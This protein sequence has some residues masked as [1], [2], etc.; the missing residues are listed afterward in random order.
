MTLS[1]AETY[2]LER[3]DWPAVRS[4]IAGQC[5][6]APG[7]KLMGELVP[8]LSREEALG[9]YQLVAQA[10]EVDRM[11]AWPGLTDVTDPGPVLSRA[12]R[13][14]VLEGPELRDLANLVVTSRSYYRVLTHYAEGRPALRSW[15]HALSP[16]DSFH[17]MLELSVDADGEL[18]ATA[19]AEL[20][21]LRDEVE[22]R[23]AGI[24][25]RLEEILKSEKF[26]PF[27]QDDFFT[28][29][30][31]RFVVPLKAGAQAQIK[32]IVHDTSNT[33][34]TVFIEPDEVIEANN[35][36]KTAAADLAREELRIRRELSTLAASHATEILSNAG[37]LI[38]AD[39]VIARV[40]FG[41]L[42]GGVVPQIT[43]E[44]DWSFC[45]EGLT[46]PLLKQQGVECVPNDLE[47]PARC[48]SL[49]LSGPNTGG[50]TVLLKSLGLA[51]L[52]VKAGVP[53][54]AA[55]GSRLPFVPA[56]YADIG[57]SQSLAGAVSTFSGHLFQIHRILEEAKA[58]SVA[59]LDELMSGTDPAEGA[60]LGRAVLEAL[61]ARRVL[62]VVSTHY[63][64]LKHLPSEGG[65]RIVAG[66]EFD[67]VTLRPTY[68]LR[69]GTP[70]HSRAIEVAGRLGFPPAIVE[71]ARALLPEAGREV[72][73]LVEE[74]ERRNQT[75]ELERNS[76]I[77]ER[78]D[79][80][81][82][83]RELRA[84]I[85]KLK[86]QEG[87]RLTS[88]AARLRD[89]VSE[90]RS[91]VKLL[92]KQAEERAAPPV[93]EVVKR[94]ESAIQRAETVSGKAREIELS[95]DPD[96]PL[97]REAAVPGAAVRLR[98]TETVGKI[99]SVPDSK[100]RLWVEFLG[101][102]TQTTL[103]RLVAARGAPARRDRKIHIPLGAKMESRLEGL[104]L[105]LHGMREEEALREVEK[106]L[107][108]AM[109]Q[110]IDSVRIIHGLGSGRLQKAVRA[111][112]SRS[113]YV[114]RFS[115]AVPQ[116]GGFGVTEV[117]LK[118]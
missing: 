116:A 110:N 75:L 7:G 8:G 107:D 12:D 112:L 76:F 42:T 30:E 101:Q 22:R 34:A 51:C 103:E 13:G 27:L 60:A 90:L 11:G 38:E 24:R 66:M 3:L 81:R 52:L 104:Q 54:P 29:R 85:E 68:R 46:H 109:A 117:I 47:I 80:E 82:T 108:T 111:Y 39:Q 88:D 53:V 113:P 67:P 99:E 115:T 37:M 93:K 71:R 77:D 18:K 58:G 69:T 86:T 5:Q 56:V 25:N 64:D 10:A 2:S 49:I 87:R 6:S 31:N 1:I 96:A 40:R 23:S 59:I 20:A 61:A 106:F 65:R 105:D 114:A 32:G 72:A 26:Q 118:G 55:E 4:L 83:E 33:G 63:D 43:P 9:M 94:A 41:K 102:R 89:E 14:A 73:R 95:R 57:D 35:K 91:L 84:E 62:S 44:G 98:G 97:T 50:K 100:G 28:I 17:D 79:L 70:G 74:L 15:F 19:S 36:L 16:L 48:E 78:K 21:R 45:L 92:R